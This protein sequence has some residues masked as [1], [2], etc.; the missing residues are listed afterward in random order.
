MYGEL[1]ATGEKHSR[2]ILMYNTG[3]SM[4]KRNKIKKYKTQIPVSTE[5]K[6]D[7]IPVELPLLV[8]V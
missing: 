5:H 2:H 8:E 4:K 6:F 1:E 7:A 3:N